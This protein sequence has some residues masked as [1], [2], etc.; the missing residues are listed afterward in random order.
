MARPNMG[1]RNA[2]GKKVPGTT[3]VLKS[4]SLLDSDILC[5][6]AAKLARA[7]QD[8][9]ATRAAA[10]AHGTMLHE[11]C[12]TRLPNAL[13]PEK[14]RPAALTSE[15]QWEKLKLSYAAIRTW[16]LQHEPRLL[17]AEEPLVSELYQFGGTPDGLVSFPRDIP[18]Y[19]VVAGEPW[20]F[21][22]K[23]GSQVGGKEVAQMSA[24]R[25]LLLETKGVA[26]HG[27]ILIHAPTKE[28][29]YM[30]PVVIPS[31]ALDTGWQ[32]FAA[33]LTVYRGA[34]VLAAVCE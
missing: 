19:G 10:G 4:L 5:S 21:D 12:E 13:D 23:T 14:D 16:W 3:T 1:Y 2:A 6:W 30:R 33:A 7:G 24:Y 26:V 31:S 34:P 17:L 18:A 20:L 11:L 29:G 25:Q 28:P 15:E 9:R 8:W 22:Y 27:A 32:L